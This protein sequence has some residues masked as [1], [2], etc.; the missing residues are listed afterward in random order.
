M[1][2]CATG[3]S[4]PCAVGSAA[5]GEP[6]TPRAPTPRESKWA[7]LSGVAAILLVVIG[8]IVGGMASAVF[9]LLALV[10]LLWMVYLLRGTFPL[11]GGG[12]TG[13]PGA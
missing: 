9:F 11:G 6:H 13:P 1:E 2:L 3:S 5:V 10:P 7:K 4:M 8:G 12:G